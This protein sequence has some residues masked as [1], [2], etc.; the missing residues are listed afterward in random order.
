MS[1]ISSA[2]TSHSDFVSIF[3]AALEN[4]KYKT[5]KDLSS[6]PLL[7]DLQSCDSS[8]AVL[9]VI[10]EQIPGQSQSDEDGLTKWISPTVNALYS[11]SATLGGGIGLVSS[12][13]MFPRQEFRLKYNLSGI[14]SR[15]HNIYGHWC[16]SLGWYP[17]WFPCAAYFDNHGSQA[18]ND[19]STGKD[20]LIELFN[21]IEHF[22]RRLEIYTGITPTT[23]MADLVIEI[24]VEVLT[25]LAIATK[26]VERGRLSELMLHRLTARD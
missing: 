24:M 9:A 1:T 22:F 14:P 13:R 23:A 12:I 2:S 6:H 20:H 15:K 7:P 8:N 3:N 17:S 5:K 19:T 4:Y 26:E 11:F 21:R 16:A 10:R 25:I 18:V